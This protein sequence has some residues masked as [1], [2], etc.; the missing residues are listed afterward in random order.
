MSLFEAFKKRPSEP[1]SQ[2]D[3]DEEYKIKKIAYTKVPMSAD[4][5]RRKREEELRHLYNAPATKTG[6]IV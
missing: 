4:I 6:D 1:V 5:A 3:E 2:Q